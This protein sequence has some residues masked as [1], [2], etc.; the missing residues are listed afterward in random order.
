MRPA[1]CTSLSGIADFRRKK[2]GNLFSPFIKPQPK[3]ESSGCV[4]DKQGESLE[5][6]A[7]KIPVAFYKEGCKSWTFV[8]F[9]PSQK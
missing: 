6:A 2:H 7:I 9:G 8:T 3:A 5:A 1:I 4:G